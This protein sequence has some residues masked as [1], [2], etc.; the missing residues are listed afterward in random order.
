[1]PE[2]K[3]FEGVSRVKSGQLLAVAE[4]SKRMQ[5]KE[6]EKIKSFSDIEDRVQDMKFLEEEKLRIFHLNSGN[7]IISEEEIEG[8]VGE[9]NFQLKD[10]FR[11]AVKNNS[12]AVILTHNH[13]SG[14]SDPTEAD[15]E[16]TREARDIGEKLGV[17]LLDHVIVGEKACSMK[18]SCSVSF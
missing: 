8:G 3:E 17:E 4:L 1:M 2:L 7:E 14:E 16:A 6:R 11:S 9:V 18:K 12:A 5:N 13:P 15:L 10:I